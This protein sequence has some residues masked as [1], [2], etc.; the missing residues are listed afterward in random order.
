MSAGLDMFNFGP[1][2]Q[3]FNLSGV[4]FLR[5]WKFCGPKMSQRCLGFKQQVNLLQR[6]IC[7]VG[8]KEITE[9]ERDSGDGAV[10]EADFG[11]E[12]GVRSVQEIRD[13][14]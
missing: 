10:D 6:P 14:E 8:H 1:I 9:D 7:A 11:L 4:Q 5:E 3:P 2:L 12:V 13:R